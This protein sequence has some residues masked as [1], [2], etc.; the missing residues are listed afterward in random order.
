[1]VNF[2]TLILL[3]CYVGICVIAVSSWLLRTIDDQSI[4]IE[5]TIDDT[6]RFESGDLL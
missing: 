5:N 4:D 1:M 3:L 2:V 6:D